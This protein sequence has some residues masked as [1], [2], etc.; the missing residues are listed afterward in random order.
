MKVA[1]VVDGKFRAVTYQGAKMLSRL[2]LDTHDSPKGGDR[3]HS[4]GRAKPT[5]PAKNVKRPDHL[6]Q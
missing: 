4:K 2:V 6:R 3:K 1:A 5:L